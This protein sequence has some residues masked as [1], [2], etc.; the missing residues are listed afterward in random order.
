MSIE[1]QI[2]RCPYCGGD[3]DHSPNQGGIEKH[4]CKNCGYVI[5]I[6]NEASKE[7]L[8]A[9][10]AFRNEVIN[11]LHAKIDGGKSERI[12]NWKRH[13][14]TLEDYIEKCGGESNQD[15]L[16]AI[17]RAAHVT[18]G[19][20]Q[21]I[22]KEAKE[23]AESLYNTAQTYVNHNDKAINI[24][25]LVSLY[26]RKL[27]NK[28]RNLL[29]GILGG[30]L[31]T[32]LVGTIIGWVFLAQYAPLLTD[33]TTGITISVPNDAVPMFEKTGIDIYV[34]E[35]PHNSVAYIDAK[36]ALHNET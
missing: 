7:K 2:L 26:K 1:S 6:E 13:E 19:F 15:P 29:C 28:P 17:A 24:K 5:Y 22:S 27:R 32:L 18:D 25:T 16:F 30:I 3:F 35:H 23:I 9:L 10:N 31:G 20:E 8:F 14:S 4:T 34:E 11:L 12:A 21:Y 33:P 36:N